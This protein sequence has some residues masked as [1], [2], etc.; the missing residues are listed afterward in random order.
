M[1]DESP[2]EFRDIPVI[3]EAFIKRLKT[4][5]HSRIVYPEAP[6]NAERPAATSDDR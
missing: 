6:K 3:K 5:Y 4:I 2:L 1:F